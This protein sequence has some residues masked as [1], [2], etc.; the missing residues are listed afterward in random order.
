MWRKFA[1]IAIA[2]VF[3]WSCGQVA[4]QDSETIE[5]KLISELVADPLGFDGQEVSFEGTITHICRHSGDK[6]RVN[7]QDDADFSIMVMLEDFQAQIN[8]EFEGKHVMLTGLLKTHVRNM[9]EGEEKHDHDH[10][11]DGEEGHA[12]ASTEEAIKRLEERGVTPDIMAYVELKSFQIMDEPME[13]V[14][15]DEDA[16]ENAELAEAKSDEDNC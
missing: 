16:D 3:M 11:H 13:V 15:E 6:M 10:A 5:M 9:D 2:G 8:N 4:E 12:C 7:Q 1:M 14:E